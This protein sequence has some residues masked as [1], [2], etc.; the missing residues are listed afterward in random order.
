MEWRFEGKVTLVTGATTG[1]AQATAVRLNE[2]AARSAAG[3]DQP[4]P[5]ARLPP[6]VPLL[7]GRL[8]DKSVPGPPFGDRRLMVTGLGRLVHSGRQT[9]A[10]ARQLPHVLRTSHGSREVRLVGEEVLP[11][12]DATALDV[13]DEIEVSDGRF[14]IAVVASGAG[15][16]EGDFGRRPIR[17]GETF[18]LSAS[19]PVHLQAGH[20]PVRVIRCLGPSIE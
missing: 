16:M 10:R 4:A 20:E 9:F 5:A 8:A 2:R 6:A 18:A 3:C 19:L 17:R 15:L 11:F 1:I 7:R 13:P 14:W 12:F